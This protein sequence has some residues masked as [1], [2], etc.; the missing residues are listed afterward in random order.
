MMSTLTNMGYSLFQ[1]LPDEL[2][3]EINL[4]ALDVYTDERKRLM[5]SVRSKGIEKIVVGANVQGPRAR[6]LMDTDGT[7]NELIN[8]VVNEEWGWHHG[9]GYWRSGPMWRSRSD[10]HV[11]DIPM[12][13]LLKLRNYFNEQIRLNGYRM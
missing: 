10:G 2:V 7:I 11:F 4:M 9:D 8:Q 1:A 6:V 3:Y 5:R 13:P 12:G